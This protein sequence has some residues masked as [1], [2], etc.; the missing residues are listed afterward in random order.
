MALELAV[1]SGKLM[2][3][4]WLRDGEIDHLVYRL[5]LLAWMLIATVGL[6]HVAAVLNRGGIGLAR[7]MFHLQLRSNDH[8]RHWPAQVRRWLRRSA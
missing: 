3:E 1:G 8:P 4:G 7:S 5:H 2:N 6:W